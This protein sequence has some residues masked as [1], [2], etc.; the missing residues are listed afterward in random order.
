MTL[1][2]ERVTLHSQLPP[3]TVWTYNGSSPG[4]TIRLRR[5]QKL[6]VNWQNEITGNFPVT[7][8]QVQSANP[9][10]TPGP[11]R[12]GVAPRPEVAVLP[13]WT[14]VHLHGAETGA[15]NDGWPENAV[16]PGNS[17]LAEY[18]NDQ[19]A[20][21]LWYHDHAM[22][23]TALNVMSGLM[24]MYLIRD[25]EE[26]ALGLPHGKHEVPLIICD[27]NLDTDADGNLTGELLHKVHILRPGSTMEEQ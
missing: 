23:I 21:A 9:F 12:D 2:T 19:Q 22:A 7:S 13:P 6:P 10:Q 11:G 17:Q 1:R 4:P 16:L 20:T 5:G 18:P 26:D 14:V 15:G 25:D 24:G 8:V 3:T 27:R